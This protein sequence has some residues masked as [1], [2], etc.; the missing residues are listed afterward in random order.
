MADWIQTGST[1]IFK[2]YPLAE[3]LRGLAEAGFV[4][5][6]IGAVKEF[7]E[8]L[9][10]DNPDVDG[11]RALLDEHGLT[12]VSM[13]GHAPLHQE[14]GGETAPQRPRGRPGA[15]DQGSQHVHGRR[16]RPGRGRG[17][18]S[19]RPRAGRRGREPGYSALHRDGL[20]PA[21]DGSRRDEAAR[22]D[23]P[24]VDRHQL[25]PGERRLLHGGEA[26]GGHP[27][28]AATPRALPPEGQA[29]R[30]RASST[31]RRRARATSTSR[32]CSATSPARGSR[33]P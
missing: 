13:S 16:G 30:R 33:A 23:R 28:R 17:V 20:E 11:C 18:Q 1:I 22:G 24:P 8:H 31:S 25:R 14:V 29:R 10:P 4:N 27:P 6:E 21:A 5:V 15:R 32:A 3:A 7:L 2:P 12:C 26:R 9:D 19:E